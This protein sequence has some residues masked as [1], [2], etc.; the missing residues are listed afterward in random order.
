MIYFLHENM[1][2]DYELILARVLYIKNVCIAGI[3]TISNLN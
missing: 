2:A 3:F 1:K